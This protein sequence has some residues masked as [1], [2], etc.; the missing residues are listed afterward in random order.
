MEVFEDLFD[1][2]GVV[3]GI[4]YLPAKSLFNDARKGTGNHDT[5]HKL[6]SNMFQCVFFDS[7]F[8]QSD[9]LLTRRVSPVAFKKTQVCRLSKNI[10]LH[11]AKTQG[12]MAQ[13]SPPIYTQNMFMGNMAKWSQMCDVR[14]PKFW[15]A[16]CP[17][18]HISKDST[19]YDRVVVLPWRA[20]KAMW[21]KLHMYTYLCTNVL[22]TPNT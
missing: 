1:R 7:P 16:R 9:V 5:S 12:W 17:R 20:M 2:K 6:H 19:R 21:K 13:H 3:W 22:F 15:S 10:Q 18:C 8:S 11:D 4:P 14:M